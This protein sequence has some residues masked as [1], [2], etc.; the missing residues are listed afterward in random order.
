[1]RIEVRLVLLFG[2]GTVAHDLKE[3]RRFLATSDDAAD[4]ILQP[5]EDGI[6][7]GRK[8]ARRPGAH[9]WPQ[10][11][12]TVCLHESRLQLGGG[13]LNEVAALSVAGEAVQEVDERVGTQLV[14]R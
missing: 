4:P 13:A 5:F 11:A 7:T 8:P 3:F 6:T 9:R 14:P 10:R 2:T 12:V 1:M